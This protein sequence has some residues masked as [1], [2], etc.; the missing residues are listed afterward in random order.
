MTSQI[1]GKGTAIAKKPR[2][3]IRS[4]LS[5]VGASLWVG[6]NANSDRKANG[7]V[8]GLWI[9]RIEQGAH[10]CPWGAPVEF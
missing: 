4:Q 7:S 9:L 2:S 5:E 3:R 6:G 8:N 10:Q 1:K